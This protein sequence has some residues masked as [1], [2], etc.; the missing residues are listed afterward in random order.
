MKKIAIIQ[1][2]YIPWKGYFDMIA[3]AD[4]FILFDHTQYTK[5]DWRN[6]NKIKTPKGTEW[7]TIPVVT[8]GRFG[9]RVCDVETVPS[10]QWATKHWKTIEQHYRRAP[11]FEEY[12]EQIQEAYLGLQESNLSQIN[13]QL[14]K[15]I[16]D[17]LGIGTQIS[18]SMDYVLAEGKTELLVSLCQAAGADHYLSGPSAQSYI[19]PELFAEAGIAIEYMDYSGYPEYPQLYTGFEHG[20]TVL[21]LMFNVGPEASRYMKYVHR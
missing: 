1:S 5:N 19:M 14:I 6:R 4:E 15:L 17:I 7:I 2:N 11:F 13:Y 3:A 8:T 18:W 12:F 21:D 10:S 20:V 9:Q 16:C